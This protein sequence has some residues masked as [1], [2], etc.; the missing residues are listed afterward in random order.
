MRLDKFISNNSEHTRSQIRKLVK[1]ERIQVNG[2]LVDDVAF[3]VKSKK[4]LVTVDGKPIKPIGSVYYMLNKPVGYVCA[5]DDGSHP[6]VIDLLKR[7][8]NQKNP[9]ESHPIPFKDLQIVGRL[10]VDTTGLVL[11]TN[12][13]DWNHRVTSPNSSCKKTYRV[14]LEE[15]FDIKTLRHF[16]HGMALEGEKK[17][18]KP[19]AIELITPKKLRLTISEGKYHQVKRMFAATGNK[20][21]KLHRESIGDIMLDPELDAGQF[22]SLSSNEVQSMNKK[23]DFI[24]LD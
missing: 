21:K 8:E 5:N 24:S 10:D 11:V 12:D 1:A 6:T 18:T 9:E 23:H 7:T 19:A 17:P 4:D 16:T 22:R 20:V 2:E 13:G 3:K 14:T 15:A